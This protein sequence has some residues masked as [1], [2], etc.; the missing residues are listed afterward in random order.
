MSDLRASE[1]IAPWL[2]LELVRHLGPVAAPESLW[3]R[4]QEPRVLLR[5]RSSRSAMWPV[6]ATLMLMAAGATAW[7]LKPVDPAVAMEKQAIEELAH[8]DRGFDFRS[9]DP[10]AI[11]NW[12]KAN[13]DI[14]IELPASPPS[15][16]TVRLLGA[17]LLQTH[18]APIAAVAYAVG[19]GTAT[20]VVSRARAKRGGSPAPKHSFSRAL[21]W[22]M[23]EQVYALACSVVNEPQ[24]ACLLCHST[25]PQRITV[26]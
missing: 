19:G 3:D 13:S 17:R 11:R 7:Q 22:T 26:Y 5:D 9:D 16:R 10:T 6:A 4:I 24:V 15:S 1:G 23:R 18:G 8:S 12:V 20:L 14:D 25:T 21:S 2:E